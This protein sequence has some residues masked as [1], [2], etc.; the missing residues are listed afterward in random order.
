MTER[1]GQAERESLETRISLSLSLDRPEGLRV[2]TGLGFLNHMLTAFATHGGFGLEVTARGD[3]EVDAHHT[4]EDVGIVLGEAL[5]RALSKGLSIER[6]GDAMV[7]MD[8]ALVQ[9]ALDLSGRPYLAWEGEW[10][11][12]PAGGLWPDVW[13]EF[14]QGLCRGAG[15]TLHVRLLTARNQHHA[16]EAT[17]KA[18]GRALRLAV[19]KRPEG[20]G[21]AG[22]TVPST[23]GRIDGWA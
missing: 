22:A 2:D 16:A 23:K 12:Y 1:V 21:A 11:P 9:V 8:E 18:V 10:P 3:L 6:F 5:R 4:V 20:N 14:F 7:P 17:F 15:V 19:R 13:P